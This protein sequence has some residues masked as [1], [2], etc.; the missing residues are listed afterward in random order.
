VRHRRPHGN[1]VDRPP[2]TGLD[3]ILRL[4]VGDTGAGYASFAHV[5]SLRPDDI[6][7]DR[8]L[9]AG[10]DSD[11]ARRAYDTAI[12]LLALELGAAVTGE[13]VETP[14]ELATLNTL[15]VDRAQGY[16]LGRPTLSRATWDSWQQRRWLPPTAPARASG[17]LSGPARGPSLAARGPADGLRA[18]EVLGRLRDQPGRRG[19]A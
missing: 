11:A 4:A 8:S 9:V 10:I 15:G 17:P 1:R 5:L 6:K 14:D 16:H 18:A 3:D 2:T 13:G 19:L 7:L 12:V